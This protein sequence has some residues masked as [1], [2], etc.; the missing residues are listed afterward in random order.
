MG[1]AMAQSAMTGQQVQSFFATLLGVPADA[2]AAD[3]ST[4]TKN[5]AQ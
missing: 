4:R 2:K 1:D 3:I 5:I